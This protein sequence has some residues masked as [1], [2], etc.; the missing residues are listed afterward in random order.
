MVGESVVA[1]GWSSFEGTQVVTLRGPKLARRSIKAPEYGCKLGDEYFERDPMP[2]AINP[3][4]FGGTPAG[5]FVAIGT[6]ASF[7]YLAIGRRAAAGFSFWLKVVA[8]GA[9]RVNMG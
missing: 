4:E 8:A 6:L 1:A 2:E 7:S 9:G 5:T 3:N